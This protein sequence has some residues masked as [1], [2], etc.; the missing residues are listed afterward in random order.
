MSLTLRQK[1]ITMSYWSMARPVFFVSALQASC[2]VSLPCRL[3]FGITLA[4]TRRK[5]LACT[6]R[7][8]L[9]CTRTRWKNRK[10]LPSW[11]RRH[12]LPIAQGSFVFHE[13]RSSRCQV[14]QGVRG[15]R[16]TFQTRRDMKTFLRRGSFLVTQPL[17]LS[18]L[19][20]MN[21]Y[22][23]RSEFLP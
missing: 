12:T 6:R 2:F 19:L 21:V 3:T 22:G 14:L 13:G 4:C 9:A 7:K 17:T 10:P 20:T 1:R 18:P 23:K 8:R 16:R 15:F 5:R 11:L